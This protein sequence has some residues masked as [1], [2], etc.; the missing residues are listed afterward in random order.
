VFKGNGTRFLSEAPHRSIEVGFGNKGAGVGPSEGK[1]KRTVYSLKGIRI[2]KWDINATE[3]KPKS[4][5]KC[6]QFHR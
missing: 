4:P 2:W 5:E 3:G 6:S 1:R